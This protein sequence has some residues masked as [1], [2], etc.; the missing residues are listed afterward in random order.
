MRFLI[1][2][3]IGILVGAVVM[4]VNNVKNTVVANIEQLSQPK[5]SVGKPQ[6]K[7]ESADRITELEHRVRTVVD[8]ALDKAADLLQDD[9]VIST[10]ELVHTKTEIKIPK[11]MIP[12]EDKKPEQTTGSPTGSV[13]GESVPQFQV[14]W[15]PFRSETS[16]RGFA[17]KLSLQLQ[18][19]FE[20]VR[21]GPGRYE[22]GFNFVNPPERAEVLDAIN[23]CG[24]E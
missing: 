20:V 11:I 6:T 13:P 9:R 15:T 23:F 8:T 1:G 7:R 5:D 3:F 24:E 16:A 21:M 14:V 2:V 12:A 4:S 17:D 18:K 10:S 22:V 19:Q